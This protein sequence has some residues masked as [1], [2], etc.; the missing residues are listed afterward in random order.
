MLFQ[1]ISLPFCS[2]PVNPTIVIK[3]LESEDGSANILR[4]FVNFLPE[5]FVVLEYW[6]AYSVTDVSGQPTGHIF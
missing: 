2:G 3:H 6:A 5:V 4:N 1:R